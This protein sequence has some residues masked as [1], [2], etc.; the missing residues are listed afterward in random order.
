MSFPRLPTTLVSHIYSFFEMHDHSRLS[1]TSLFLNAVSKLQ[2]SLPR[3]LV[4]DSENQHGIPSSA[5]YLQRMERVDLR[6][7]TL[8]Q[9]VVCT[10]PKHAPNLCE[11]LGP[12]QGTNNHVYVSFLSGLHKLHT[13]R[14]AT[15]FEMTPTTKPTT[16][17]NRNTTFFFFLALR[18]LEVE[19]AYDELFCNLE[20]SGVAARLVT[21]TCRR[22][23]SEETW[24]VITGQPWYA[25]TGF[26]VRHNDGTVPFSYWNKLMSAAPMLTNLGCVSFRYTRMAFHPPSMVT[27]YSLRL[28]HAVHTFCVYGESIH[29]VAPHLPNAH[30]MIV[31]SIGYPTTCN[32][33]IDCLVLA[34]I[35]IVRI[36]Q[37]VGHMLWCAPLP[38][39]LPHV[40]T[41]EVVHDNPS[42]CSKYYHLSGIHDAFHIITH[43]TYTGFVTTAVATALGRELVKLNHLETIHVYPSDMVVSPPLTT[44]TMCG[45][46]ACAHIPC[47][48]FN[49]P[50]ASPLYR[51]LRL[52]V[53]ALKSPIHLYLCFRKRL[54]KE[55][56]GMLSPMQMPPLL[57]EIDLYATSRG[58]TFTV[59]IMP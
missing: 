24:T 40:H 46:H 5:T 4:L 37:P 45:E 18:H 29:Q 19:T 26:H 6:S 54:V 25:L 23:P 44:A 56:Q 57:Q 28:L 42:D 1:C 36:H 41:L 17:W 48:F 22:I 34:A 27:Y 13:L 39:Q 9:K 20:K 53:G 30:T 55:R 52:L 7:H 11:F 59:E 31:D 33:K 21:F 51:N 8:V 47:L 38:I 50:V 43:F 16:T 32:K 14:L 10:I 49:D 12:V 15:Q 2:C 58:I 3:C 35:R